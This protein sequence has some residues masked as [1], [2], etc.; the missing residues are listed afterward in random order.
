MAGLNWGWLAVAM[1]A[2]VAPVHAENF[3]VLSLDEQAQMDSVLLKYLITDQKIG[4]A[5]GGDFDCY[6]SL[7]GRA[8]SQQ[9]LDSVGAPPGRL[10]PWT[11]ADA[12]RAD[13]KKNHIGSGHNALQVNIG[14]FSM[15]GADTAHAT[16][17]DQCGPA[18]CGSISTATMKKT[19]DGW[20]VQSFTTDLMQ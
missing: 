17:R 3:P 13:P 10:R 14:G 11:A 8:P 4:C 19:K 6:V 20:I 9:Y 12:V 18:L 5:A 15:I 16:V 7:Q 2:F 1:A